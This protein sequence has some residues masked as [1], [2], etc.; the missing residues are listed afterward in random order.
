MPFINTIT[1]KSLTKDLETTLKEKFGKAIELLPG[2]SEYWLMLGFEGGKSMAFRGDNVSDMAYIEVKLLG[3]APKSA[4]DAMTKEL[5]N[6]VNDVL[7]IDKDKIYIKYEEASV[8]GYDGS[9]F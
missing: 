8:W 2:K 6:I 7:G 4:Y 9:N 5:T 1:T 3:S